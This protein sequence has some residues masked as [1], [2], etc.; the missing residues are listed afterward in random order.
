VSWDFHL[1]SLHAGLILTGQ[2]LK[3]YQACIPFE[4]MDK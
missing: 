3:P 4:N 2:T 1:F